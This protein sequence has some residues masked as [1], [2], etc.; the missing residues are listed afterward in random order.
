MPSNFG[1]NNAELGKVIRVGYP[2]TSSIQGNA[3]QDAPGALSIENQVNKINESVMNEAEDSTADK[4]RSDFGPINFKYSYDDDN[5]GSSRKGGAAYRKDMLNLAQQQVDKLDDIYGEMQKNSLL[6]QLIFQSMGEG[7]G[8]VGAGVVNAGG[9]MASVGGVGGLGGAGG[10]LVGGML[11]GAAGSLLKRMLPLLGEALG[12]GGVALGGV[13]LGSLAADYF[14]NKND[15]DMHQSIDP[16]ASPYDKAKTELSRSRAYLRSKDNEF[17]WKNFFALRP[18]ELSPDDKKLEQSVKTIDKLN[19]NIQDLQRAMK[20]LTQTYEDGKIS[21]DKYLKTFEEMN[22]QLHKSDIRR[23]EEEE[24]INKILPAVEESN[25]AKISDYDRDMQ[26]FGTSHGYVSPLPYLQGALPEGVTGGEA[27]GMP[28]HGTSSGRSMAP[29]DKGDNNL[30]KSNATS[31]L[32]AGFSQKQWDAYRLG[33]TD[34]ESKGGGYGIRGGAGNN[35]LGKYQMGHAEIRE[36]A[37]RLKLPTPSDEEFLHNPAMQEKFFENYTMDHYNT[38]MRIS[39]KFRNMTKEQQLE[40][41]GYGH[42]QGVAN[43]VINTG[44]A[45]IVGAAAAIAGA[46]MG[47]DAFGTGGGV[48]IKSIG[49]RLAQIDHNQEVAQAPHRPVTQTPNKTLLA[50]FEGNRTPSRPV[51]RTPNNTLLAEYLKSQERNPNLEYMSHDRAEALFHPED[52]GYSESNFLA[53]NRMSKSAADSI[54]FPE[55]NTTGILRAE[56]NQSMVHDKTAHQHVT[57]HHSSSSHEEKKKDRHH[58]KKPDKVHP[59]LAYLNQLFTPQNGLH[60]IGHA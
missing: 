33:V 35:Y 10:G 42:N 34:I 58:D 41:L 16:N 45:H 50:E 37:Q 11:G 9:D 19:E 44:R 13:I 31:A 21:Y 28:Y 56:S 3:G 53:F 6:L 39:P 48:Y 17:T 23:Q 2:A 55:Q 18:S 22:D 7:S 29:N 59:D 43:K 52:K 46:G 60:G 15:E 26:K 40:W 12:S 51:S 8:V 27:K 47:N 20:Q 30:I 57:H 32:Q 38:L 54:L 49:K 4:A 1:E 5:S 14:R 24:K 36:T 25:N